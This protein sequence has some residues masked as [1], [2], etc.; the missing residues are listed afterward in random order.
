MP[1]EHACTRLTNTILYPIHLLAPGDIAV[2]ANMQLKELDLLNCHNLTGRSDSGGD[3]GET[4]GPH[5]HWEPFQESSQESPFL[6]ILPLSPLLPHRRHRGLKE[7]A[8]HQLE[9]V[10]LYQ[11]H[12]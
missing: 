11:A 5:P 1:R 9:L 3:G 12:R 2:L 10:R 7:Y 4:S 8:S 6:L